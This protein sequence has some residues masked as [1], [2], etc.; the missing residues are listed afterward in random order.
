MLENEQWDTENTAFLT[1]HILLAKADMAIVKDCIEKFKKKPSNV[2]PPSPSLFLDNLAIPQDNAFPAS[3]F[4]R[5]NRPNTE[6]NVSPQSPKGLL[7][8]AKSIF[9]LKPIPVN[10]PAPVP[11]NLSD[12]AKECYDTWAAKHPNDCVK[13]PFSELYALT[14]KD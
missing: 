7:S 2:N 9:T 8:W 10:L 3:C 6:E 12:V 5:P 14:K 13:N 4:D 1:L 11:V